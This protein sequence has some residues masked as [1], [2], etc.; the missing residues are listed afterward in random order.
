MSIRIFIPPYILLH[1]TVWAGKIKAHCMKR[2]FLADFG[3]ILESKNK[4]NLMKNDQ[5][6]AKNV[7]WCRKGCNYDKNMDNGNRY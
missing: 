5:I 2:Q 4:I 7:V 3:L 6:E 1:Y